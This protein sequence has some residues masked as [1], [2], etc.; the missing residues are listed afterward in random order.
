MT[1]PASRA[2]N[3]AAERPAARILL[4]EDEAEIA[5]SIRE[6]LSE[7]EVH[8][9]PN[10]SSALLAIAR[11][12]FDLVLLDLRLPG[13]DGFEVLSALKA[14]DE[15]DH[16]PVVVLTAHGAT[17]EKV[18]A[19]DMGAH[20]FITKPFSVSEL[21]A[22]VRAATRAKR[23]YD[24][25]VARTAE[26]EAARDAAEHAARAKSEFVANMSHEIRTPMNG[27]IA[28]T[29]LLLGTQLT[30][31]QRE[32]V[33]TIR[34]S[35]ESL[36]TIIDDILN[37]SK[38]QAGKLEAEKHP[39]AL[40]ECVEGAIDVLAPK[41]A[42]KNI[43]LAFEIDPE[44]RN[45]VIGD[46][47]RVR[48]V[49]INLLGNAVKFTT[50]GEVVLTVRLDKPV[51]GDPSAQLVRF[52]V[53][54][55]GIGIAPDRLEKLF[56]P[57][58]QAGSS[59]T[60]EFGGTGLGLAISKGLAAIMGGQLWAESTPG[61]GSTF[62]CTLPLPATG[63]PNDVPK[64]QFAGKTVLIGLRNATVTGIVQRI[65]ERCGGTC[66]IHQD[67]A[68]LSA[69]MRTNEFSAV[70]L[71]GRTVADSSVAAALLTLRSPLLCTTKLGSG[72]P[73]LPGTYQKRVIHGPVKAVAIRAALTDLFQVQP[74]F[75]ATT[76]TVST[77]PPSTASRP[78]VS[79][80]AK[81]QTL[82]D[83]LPLRIL[84][85]DDNVINQKV[86]IRLLQQFGYTAD[87]AESG[88]DALAALSRTQYDLVFMDVQMPGMDGLE[89]TRRIRAEEK[90][91]SRP[92]VHIIAMTANAMVGDRDK[93]LASG[94]DDYLAKPVRAE[95]LQA[96]IERSKPRPQPTPAPV[97]ATPASDAPPVPTSLVDI[98]HLLDFAGGSRTSLIE[99]TDLY[100]NQTTEQL[101]RLGTAVR[102]GDA[103][104]AARIA[105]SSAGASGVCGMAAMEPLFRQAERA[106]KENKLAEVSALLPR[107]NDSFEQVKSWLL[108][109]RQN[110]PLS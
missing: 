75:A 105:H 23:G 20:D 98:E 50:V 66:V 76:V 89:T 27:V 45:A 81:G 91:L 92:P 59:I 97:Q 7:Y 19:F 36:L 77:P 84:V 21:R 52:S 62:H 83:R 15:F 58:V 44:I 90:A 43:E 63:T 104:A 17:E 109:S 4:V 57:F 46:Q 96:A 70:V 80:P 47:A 31:E 8:V 39:F 60:R 106:A 49:L 32:Y 73:A 48:Q 29:G 42:E 24:A 54:D 72:N 41:A 22:R 71:D 94:M 1:A 69:A 26:F 110:L 79:A 9:S 61:Q 35:G 51:N 68:A 95:A 53:R 5:A 64:C 107:L 30:S 3:T 56:Q 55:T 38:I 67:A 33:E 18:R 78:S 10:G 11:K 12:S 86:A 99:I 100:I 82:A 87:V 85:T 25:L 108:S 88:A 16:I 13:M 34:T 65:I 103:A 28:M 40:N 37:I 2:S 101:G 93:C 74:A 6:G 102:D 14:S